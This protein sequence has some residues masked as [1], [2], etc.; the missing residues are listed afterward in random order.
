MN[1]ATITHLDQAD[2]GV[3]LVKAT[4]QGCRK[5]VMHGAGDDPEALILGHRASHCGCAGYELADPN[6]VIPR[7]LR[8]IAEENAEKAARKAE[9][10]ARRQ[11]AEDAR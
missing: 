11:A 3:F 6:D 10:R 1:T 5:T 7:R 2:D 4:C 9:A 8:E